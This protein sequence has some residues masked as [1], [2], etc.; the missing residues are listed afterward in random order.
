MYVGYPLSL[1]VLPVFVRRRHLTA[2]I[3]PAISLVVSAFNEA[4][5]IGKKLKNSLSLDY[6]ASRGVPVVG[7]D[8]AV[9]SAAAGSSMGDRRLP[10]QPSTWGGIRGGVNLDPPPAGWG[11]GLGFNLARG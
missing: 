1:C 3:T 11:A 6:P 2:D 10:A 8:R 5:V 4:D 9:R 7:R